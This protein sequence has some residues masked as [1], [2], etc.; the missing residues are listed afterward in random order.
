M[1]VLH[2]AATTERYRK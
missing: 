2:P 1:Q